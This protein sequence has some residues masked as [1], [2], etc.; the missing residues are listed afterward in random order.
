MYVNMIRD[1]LID[2]V[3]AVEDAQAQN[4]DPQPSQSTAAAA[5]MTS[6]CTN[7]LPSLPSTLRVQ[8]VANP[9]WQGWAFEILLNG[10]GSLVG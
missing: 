2:Q 6:P 3:P 4:V 8:V 10:P 7:S 9:A 5:L 1:A